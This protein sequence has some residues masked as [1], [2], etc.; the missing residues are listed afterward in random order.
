MVKCR[1]F[2]LQRFRRLKKQEKE[3]LCG[4]WCTSN[5][6][7]DFVQLK[8]LVLIEDFK[9]RSPGESVNIFE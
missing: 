6:V 1:R 2:N 3:S 4:C 8:Q 9:K 7:E 5:E